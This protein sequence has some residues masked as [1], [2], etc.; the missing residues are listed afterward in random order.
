MKRF[1]L[2]TEGL[3]AA[4]KALYNCFDPRHCSKLIKAGRHVRNPGV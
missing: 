2:K 4:K 3:T 1:G